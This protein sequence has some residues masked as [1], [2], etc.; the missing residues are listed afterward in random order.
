MICKICKNPSEKIFEKI[1]LQKYNAN[2]YR[3]TS[4]SFVQTDQPT[5]LS[6]AYESAITSLDIGLPYRNFYLRDEVTNIINACFPES[7]IYLDF[8]GG[9]GLFVRLMRDNGFNFYRQDDYCKNIFAKHFDIIDYNTTSFDIVTAF[10]VF[11]HFDNP[12]E[13]IEKIFSYSDTVI[14]STEITPE[15]NEEIENW[16][17]IAQETGQH[18]AFYS[19]KSMKIIAKKYNKNYYTKNGNLH[20]F[21]PKELNG[22]QI[23]FAFRNKKKKYFWEKSYQKEFNLKRP[24][25]LEI[26][27]QFI[28]NILN[29]SSKK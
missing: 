8:A 4:C 7:K 10:E 16:W 27:Y 1:I 26:D 2:Y 20:L 3:C 13:E 17:Y 12:L 22:K 15:T 18:I 28:K 25:L 6:E 5:W 14:F 24:S 19:K 29:N 11:E 9:Y 23:D 21:T